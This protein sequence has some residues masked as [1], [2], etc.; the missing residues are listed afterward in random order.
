M[1]KVNTHKARP[2]ANRLTRGCPTPN[3]DNTKQINAATI[4]IK[5]KCAITPPL[6]F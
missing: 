2:A 4:K 5:F 1:I 3:A 6:E